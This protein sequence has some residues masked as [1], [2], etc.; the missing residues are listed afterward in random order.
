MYV[1]KNALRNITRAKGRNILIFIL[2]LIIAVSACVAL[3]IKSSADKTREETLASM[4]VSAQITPDRSS[5]ME[6]VRGDSSSMQ[7][8][9]TQFSQ[10]MSLDDYTLYSQAQSVNDFYYTASFG[11]NTTE[12][13][14]ETYS[15]GSSNISGGAQGMK[16]GA[17]MSIG[18]GG[19]DFTVTGYSS[20]DAMTN[21]VNSTMT[22]T[23][24][25]MFDIDD[26]TNSA[27]ISE[28]VAILNELEV[29]DTFTLVNPNNEEELIDITVSSIFAC[30]STD[31]YAN[32]IYMSYNSMANIVA[33]SEEVA[34][35]Y[36]EERTGMEMSSALNLMTNATYLLDSPEMLSVFESEVVALGLDSEQYIVTSLDL[37]EF[38]QVMLPLENL[39]NFT[40]I[41]F[42]V[43]IAIGAVILIVFNLFTV[44]ERKYEIG[45]LAAIG[46]QKSKV[47]L[48]FLTEVL[49]VTFVA[50][51]VGAV[52]G[53]VISQPIGDV[54]LAE[55]IA[56]T[57][58]TNQQVS[59]NFGGNFTGRAGMQMVGMTQGFGQNSVDYIDSIATSFDFNVLLQLMGVGIMLSLFAS[60]MGMI[61]VLRYEPL[62]ILSERA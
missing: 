48:Q 54:L 32:D 21:F 28:E 56:Q 13:G 40:M 44:R 51:L 57:S 12:D 45:V 2:V 30:E 36:T 37:V 38:E 61:A 9:M 16:M 18:M 8:L 41:F 50:V 62:K 19:G 26:E 27:S 47:A 52:V 42:W 10:G 6:R 31:A 53:V 39:S 4:N 22:I 14:I 25:A 60:I 55:Q 43:V 59:D 1:I 58:V 24:G 3:S 46:M 11:L 15:T 35:T 5:M 49:V 7:D 20:H 17:G 29:G 34:T 33:N 23:E